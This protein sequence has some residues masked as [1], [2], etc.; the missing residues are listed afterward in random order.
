MT[1]LIGLE[2][3]GIAAAKRALAAA[4]TSRVAAEVSRAVG[5][6]VRGKLQRYPAYSYVSRR[7]AYGKPFFSDRQRRWF[8][9][10]LRNGDLTIPYQRTG[11]LRRGWQLL[12]SGDADYLLVNETP[13]AKYVQNSPQARMMTLRQWRT[14]QRIVYEEARG[15]VTIAQEALNRAV[16]QRTKA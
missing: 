5:E 2:V 7:E 10:A 15:I 8:F 6:Y 9:A 13:Y 3:S 11:A 1:E 4:N 12:E 14:V 16:K